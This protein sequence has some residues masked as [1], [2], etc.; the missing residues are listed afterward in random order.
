MDVRL[1]A[2]VTL[3]DRELARD[4]DVALVT[5]ADADFDATGDLLGDG[6]H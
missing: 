1:S 2:A 3:L 5:D 6:G 4:C